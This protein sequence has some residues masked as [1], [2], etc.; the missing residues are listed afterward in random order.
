MKVVVDTNVLVS[1]VFFGGNPARVLEA[2]RDDLVQLVVSA[3]ILEEYRRVGERLAS[4]HEGVALGPFLALLATH[5]EIV[6]PVSLPKQISRDPADDAFIA[7]A[8]SGRCRYIISGDNDLLE[9][10]SYRKVKNV[11]PRAFVD[12]VLE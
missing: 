10:G 7:C 1:G 4:Q 6:E 11:T 8:V 2:W 12:A 3:E 5:A 9:V